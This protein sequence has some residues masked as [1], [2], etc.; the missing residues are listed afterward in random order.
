VRNE[1]HGG[2]IT[3]FGSCA[4]VLE[5]AFSVATTVLKPAS[6]IGMVNQPFQRKRPLWP[7]VSFIIETTTAAT[8]P[9]AAPQGIDEPLDK[10][11]STIDHNYWR[12][13]AVRAP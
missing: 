13:G 12:R 5:F 4:L 3:A 7:S 1:L 10:G 6:A 8:A 9:R 2:I 11:R